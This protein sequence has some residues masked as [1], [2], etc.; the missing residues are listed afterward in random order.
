MIAKLTMP[1]SKSPQIVGFPGQTDNGRL[2]LRMLKDSMIAIV[3][4]AGSD[5]SVSELTKSSDS[6]SND[7]ELS[8]GD[9]SVSSEQKGSNAY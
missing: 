7:E 3:K 9:I 4:K 8:S 2:M 1:K 5:M 6:N